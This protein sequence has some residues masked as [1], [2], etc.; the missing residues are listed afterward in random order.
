L[1]FPEVSRNPP[2]RQLRQFSAILVVLVLIIGV[3][4]HWPVAWIGAGVATGLAGVIEPST[5]RPIFVGWMLAVSPIRW[6]VSR[7]LLGLVFYGVVTPIGLVLRLMG[8]NPMRGRLDP[9]APTYWEP[10]LG[11]GDVSS[12]FR[13][14]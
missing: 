12:Y 14:Y 11:S 9:A 4:R 13:Q 2:R 7:V 8:H 5:A 1:I 10:K 3:A 6:A